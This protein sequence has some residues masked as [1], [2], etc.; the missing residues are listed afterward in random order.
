MNNTKN[1]C[2]ICPRGCDLRA[3]HCARGAEYARSGKQPPAH[4][5]RLQFA[6]KEQQLIMKHLHHAVGAA[7]RGGLTQT[8]AGQMFSV[9]SEAETKQLCSLLERLADHWAQ[10]APNKPARPGTPQNGEKS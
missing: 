7:D 6:T 1:Q 5:T 4:Q 9:L 3:P 8:Q 10:L 2:P